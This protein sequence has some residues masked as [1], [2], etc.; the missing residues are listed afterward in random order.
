MRQPRETKNLIVMVTALW[1]MKLHL[2][3]AALR[4]IQP[5]CAQEVQPLQ[6]KDLIRGVSLAGN[7]WFEYTQG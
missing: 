1:G 5:I 2:V 4:R 3:S 7:V 6:G